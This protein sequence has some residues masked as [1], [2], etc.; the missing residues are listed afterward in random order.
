MKRMQQR[1]ER[2]ERV[3]GDEADEVARLV[4]EE[5]V[6]DRERVPHDRVLALE[7]VQPVRRVPRPNLT[8]AAG[9][10]RQKAV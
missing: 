8:T 2:Q 6:D 5:L 3:V 4:V 7:P 9:C 10:A 1:E